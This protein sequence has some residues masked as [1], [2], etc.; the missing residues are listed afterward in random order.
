MNLAYSY[1]EWRMISGGKRYGV[2][3]RLDNLA[4]AQ[5]G[6]WFALD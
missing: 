3:W 2:N 1:I 5:F 4:V 6:D